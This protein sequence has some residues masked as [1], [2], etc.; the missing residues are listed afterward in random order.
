VLAVVQERQRRRREEIAEVKFLKAHRS[1]IQITRTQ[2]NG[3]H[4]WFI[5]DCE[6]YIPQSSK[7]RPGISEILAY[8][9]K[10]VSSWQDVS[11]KALSIV[12]ETSLLPLS[13]TL[14]IC[15]PERSNPGGF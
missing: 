4:Y 11:T 2:Y 14:N 7:K 3:L 13:G 9:V 1:H 12:E 10:S 15:L 6:I 8:V 5:L